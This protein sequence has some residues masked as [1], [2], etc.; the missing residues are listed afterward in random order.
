M[1]YYVKLSVVFECHDH[2]ALH[3]IVNACLTEVR[4]SGCKEAE[5]YLT[6]LLER[7]GLAP[8]PKGGMSTWGM[9][10]N[11]TSGE[12]F[13]Q[14]LAPFWFLVLAAQEGGMG[15]YTK[16][17]VFVQGE[18]ESKATAYEIFREDPE[19]DHSMTVKKHA[20]PFSWWFTDAYEG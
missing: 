16:I 20:C 15:Q 3:P 7:K 4:T 12:H 1:G 8:G 13:V 10:G 9:V 19:D 17:M 18:D 14:A 11:Y 6:Q 5:W 2:E